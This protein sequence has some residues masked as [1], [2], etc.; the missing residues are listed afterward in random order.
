MSNNCVCHLP[1]TCYFSFGLLAKI[2]S[3]TKEKIIYKLR[4]SF[5]HTI[6]II[7]HGIILLFGP[8]LYLNPSGAETII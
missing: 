1:P 4:E 2:S 5:G 7:C 3:V 8:I 6:Y